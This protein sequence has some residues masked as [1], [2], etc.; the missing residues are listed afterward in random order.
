MNS[1]IRDFFQTDRSHDP[2][3]KDVRFLSEE[4]NLRWKDV[5]KTGLSRSWFELTRISKEER[6]EFSR[7]FWLSRFSFHPEATKGLLDF[8]SKLD[9]VA[10]II[11]RQSVEESWSSELVYSLRDNSCFFR[12]RPAAD[13][14]EIEWAKGLNNE[15]FPQDYWTFFHIHNGFGKLNELGL[16]TLDD[17]S[18]AKERLVN[19]CLKSDRPLRMNETWMDPNSLFPFYEEYGVGS[20]QCF[21]AEWY[22]GSEM[23]NVYFSSID[24][25]ISD[26]SERKTWGEHFAFPTFLEWFTVFLEGMYRP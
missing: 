8:F 10:V 7:E 3:F 1:Q 15:N 2:H 13:E 17:L 19:S 26:L 12:G 14:N 18:D 23:G 9:D 6:V 21:N 11:C 25:T 5:E 20:F 24:T 22:P 16:M 4:S